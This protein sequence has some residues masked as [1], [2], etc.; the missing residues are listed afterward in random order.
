MAVQVP[1]KVT[2][3]LGEAAALY[4]SLA[5]KENMTI[6]QITW[7]KRMLDRSHRVAVFH[8]KKGPSIVESER[9]MFLSARLD[10]DPRNASLAISHLSAE[11]EGS[12]EC[13]FATFPTGSKGSSVW[14]KVLGKC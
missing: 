8:P 1:S 2:G 12:Y 5:S 10:E 11:D 7:M 4:C 14:L 6:T 9:V 13:Q 3:F